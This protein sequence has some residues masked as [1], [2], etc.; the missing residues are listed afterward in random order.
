MKV[1]IYIWVRF[2]GN[3]Q[4]GLR[5]PKSIILE[6]HKTNKI[7]LKYRYLALFSIKLYWLTPSGSV[8]TSDP[9]SHIYGGEHPTWKQTPKTLLTCFTILKVS[10]L[11]QI[12]LW[13]GKIRSLM[14]VKK[15]YWFLKICD[16]QL[17]PKSCPPVRKSVFV[18]KHV[19][20]YSST[21]NNAHM[22]L[23][24]IEN[25]RYHVFFQIVFTFGR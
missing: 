5:G 3:V 23:K 10:G 2:Y 22:Q 6:K 11:V 14:F 25:T 7:S 9:R 20:L 12:I 17:V 13:H 19:Y 15:Q 24:P 1:Y 4:L 21:L 8:F 16:H 18:P